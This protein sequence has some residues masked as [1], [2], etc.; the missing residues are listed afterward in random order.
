MPDLSLQQILLLAVVAV[1]GISL[2]AV[3]LR[4]LRR[5]AG[6]VLKIGCALLVLALLVAGYLAW[7]AIS[8]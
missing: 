3:A 2:A 5:A 7:L 1:V 4:L 8:G 6:L